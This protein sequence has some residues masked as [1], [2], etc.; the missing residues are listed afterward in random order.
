MTDLDADRLAATVRRDRQ[1]AAVLQAA[2]DD[3]VTTREGAA[4]LL[5]RDARTAA[6]LAAAV[7]DRAAQRR[8]QAAQPDPRVRGRTAPT[9]TELH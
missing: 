6:A 8:R 7:E 3:R 4:A 1:T 5:D 2:I 9:G